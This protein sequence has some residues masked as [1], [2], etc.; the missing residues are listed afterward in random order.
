MKI[1]PDI[2]LLLIGYG[3]ALVLNIAEFTRVDGLS[4]LLIWLFVNNVIYAILVIIILRVVIWIGKKAG[5]V[6]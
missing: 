5:F 6:K 4:A 2:K 1:L 3:I